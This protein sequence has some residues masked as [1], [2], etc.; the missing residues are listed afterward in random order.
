MA[1][2]KRI[3]I[4][5]L[6]VVLLAGV[7]VFLYFYF[8]QGGSPPVVGGNDLSLYLNGT[9]I[10]NGGSLGLLDSGQEFTVENAEK[11]DVQIYA[12]C[13]QENDFALTVGE[14]PYTW[15][16][17]EGEEPYTWGDFDGRNLTAGFDFA[18]TET[19][20]TITHYGLNDVLSRIQNG[21]TVK[22]DKF[23]P[24]PIFRMSVT[25]G[26]ESLETYFY[27]NAEVIGI[28]LDQSAIIF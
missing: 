19:G 27:I 1:K 16:D 9:K 17:F 14:E 7:G 13:T 20:F 5:L 15:G 26:E 8:T 12:Y 6:V 25:A 4:V 10:E 22:T 28:S 24:V 2:L 11:Y 3:L 18:R 23:P 21:M